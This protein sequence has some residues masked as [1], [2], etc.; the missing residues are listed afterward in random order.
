MLGQ[1]VVRQV[2]KRYNNNFMCKANFLFLFLEQ[3]TVLEQ[4]SF[5]YRYPGS[6]IELSSPGRQCIDLIHN[7]KAQPRK[8]N[9]Y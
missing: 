2:D 7:K 8:K 6:E 1:F 5:L 9:Y 3:A 4:S